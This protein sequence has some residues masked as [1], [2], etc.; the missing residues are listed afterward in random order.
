MLS[1]YLN[2]LRP[3]DLWLDRAAEPPPGPGWDPAHDAD[4]K[5]PYLVARA[6]RQ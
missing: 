3:H 2:T 4:R 6:V 5:P 1:T